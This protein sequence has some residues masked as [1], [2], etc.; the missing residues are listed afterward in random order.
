[1]VYCRIPDLV[2]IGEAVWVQELPKVE[3]LVRYHGFATIFLLAGGDDIR[4]D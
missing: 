4:S 3:N 1:M 2:T